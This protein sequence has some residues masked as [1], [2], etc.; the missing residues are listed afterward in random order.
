MSRTSSIP[1]AG[2]TTK[3]HHQR[4]IQALKPLAFGF[5]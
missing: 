5:L 4:R 2:T 3:T 1:D